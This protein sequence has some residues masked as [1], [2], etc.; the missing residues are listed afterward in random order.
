[1]K[2]GEPILIERAANGWMVRSFN[3][4]EMVVACIADIHVF[5]SM[6]YDQNGAQS[7]LTLFG[8][9]LKHFAALREAQDKP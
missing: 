7:D 3:G 9:L 6:D 4:R 2:P 1:V 8:F 5:Q